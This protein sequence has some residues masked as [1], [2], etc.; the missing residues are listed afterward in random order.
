MKHIYSVYTTQTCFIHRP[1][2][3]NALKKCAY[4]LDLPTWYCQKEVP[5]IVH[6]W[7]GNTN[8][9][10]KVKNPESSMI[11]K[12]KN[13]CVVCCPCESQLSGSRAITGTLALCCWSILSM[14]NSTLIDF[15]WH[16]NFSSHIKRFSINNR[17]C[18]TENCEFYWPLNFSQILA[19]HH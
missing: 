7:K 19:L 17:N 1:T 8:I 11:Q 9:L 6:I 10:K 18:T 3:K 13:T 12:R 14:A 5:L 15:Y 2:I 4:F 16:L